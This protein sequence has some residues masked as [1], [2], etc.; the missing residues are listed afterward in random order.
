M[1]TARTAPRSASELIR[2]IDLVRRERY[3]FGLFRL[4]EAMLLVGI[5]FSPLAKDFV[6]LVAP[7][8]ARVA[9]LLFLL[10]AI[11]LLSW[12]N[13][14]GGR[15]AAPTLIGLALDIIVAGLTLF[16]TQGMDSSVALLL[17]INLASG[18]VLLAPRI[19]FV[20]AILAVAVGFLERWLSISLLGDGEER[21]MAEVIVVGVGYLAVSW[22]MQMLRHEVRTRQKLVE[23]RESDVESL[24]QLND[25]IIRRMK[26]GVLV[27][28]GQGRIQRIN[29]S[30]WH[31][32]GNPSPT[33][34]DIGAISPELTRRLEQ[35][36]ASGK[37]D[38]APAAL[39]E[40]SQ[41]VIPRFVAV[42]QSAQRSVIVFLEDTAM[43]TRQAEQ[44][45]LSSLG[46]LSASIAHE[47]RNPLAAISHAAQLLA[48]SEDLHDADVRLLEIIRSQCLRM[49]AIV[50]NILQLSRRERSKPELLQLNRWVSAFVEEF[51][52]VQPLGG[53][54]LR[55][56]IPEG[57]IS[58]VFDSDQLQQV[59]WNLA[60]NAL[61]HGRMPDQPARV[62]I[63]AR[64]LPESGQPVL[65]VVDRGPGI[66]EKMRPH[67][68]DP[69]FTTNEHG[70]GLGL[71][72]ARQLCEANQ[73]TLE[74]VSV[75]GGGACFRV[76]FHAQ[77]EILRGV[78]EEEY[79]GSEE[80]RAS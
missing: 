48:E 63:V 67:V 15:R 36:R 23:E 6:S 39:V 29:E 43:A 5:C 56:I 13:S 79:F 53:D 17:M 74:L 7:N 65:E 20:F 33:I 14:S 38:F 12:E 57:G 62:S 35:W 76:A 31:V 77:P 2:N 46:R 75:A 52:N 1:T 37:S 58:V 25:L 30:A 66:P 73:A 70:T 34:K 27:L 8:V 22:L 11:G 68:F 19:A 54:E 47:V 60:K 3:F 50:E 59:T 64:R 26:S 49:N 72:I 71:Y 18:G 40:R 78:G 42:P 28:D 9:S 61:R 10:G 21:S 45:T 44:M 55:A 41:E 4:F 80:S 24:S 51:R 69:F 16:T 32:L